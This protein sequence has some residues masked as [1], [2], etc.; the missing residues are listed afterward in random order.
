[1]DCTE[2]VLYWTVLYWEV[3]LMFCPFRT[4]NAF[5]HNTNTDH[6]L[7]NKHVVERKSVWQRQQKMNIIIF[8]NVE[9]V[10]DQLYWIALSCIGVQNNGQGVCVKGGKSVFEMIIILRRWIMTIISIYPYSAYLYLSIN[11]WPQT[12]SKISPLKLVVSKLT[13]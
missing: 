6:D 12:H 8:L 2:V 1:M 10:A 13:Y 3:F 7:H 11:M 4:V 9:F 5:Q